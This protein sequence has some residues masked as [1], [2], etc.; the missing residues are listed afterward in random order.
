DHEPLLSRNAEGSNSE[1]R[2][3][4]ALGRSGTGPAMKVVAAVEASV[5]TVGV[6][7]AGRRG[8]RGTRRGSD[9]AAAPATVGDEG[10]DAAVG[11]AAPSA[12]LH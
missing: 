11:A 7:P 5:G 10:A 3:G 1:F 12:S 9:T 8:G 2:A 6:S 4:V